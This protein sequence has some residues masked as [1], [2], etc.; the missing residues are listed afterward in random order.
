MTKYALWNK[1]DAVYT[2]S[3]EVFTA[4]EWMNRY[5]WAGLAQAKPVVAGGVINGA[6][7][8]ELNDMAAMYEKYGADF[9]ACTTDG[10]ILA[11]IEAFEDQMNA[12]APEPELSAEERSAAA[13]EAIAAGQTSENSA[14]LDALLTGEETK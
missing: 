12:P 7:M 8:G 11:A 3:G 6:F 1:Q 13:L 4:Q 2:P 9:S 5:S 14:A 10:Q